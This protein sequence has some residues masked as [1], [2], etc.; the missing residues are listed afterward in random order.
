[1]PGLTPRVLPPPLPAG[2]ARD[3]WDFLKPDDSP[4]GSPGARPV[5][6]AGAGLPATLQP[7]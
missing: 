1:V 5:H 7:R 6:E 3:E 2:A 4:V